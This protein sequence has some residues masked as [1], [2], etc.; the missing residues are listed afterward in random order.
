MTVFND[1]LRFR[2]NLNKIF[3]SVCYLFSEVK[4][5]ENRSKLFVN[6]ANVQIL[7]QKSFSIFK[8]ENIFTTEI[9]YHP[10]NIAYGTLIFLEIALLP[11]PV[12]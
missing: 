3:V 10:T 5:V 7:N 9:K 11:L 12:R 6:R 2:A 4:I 8:Y 1:L